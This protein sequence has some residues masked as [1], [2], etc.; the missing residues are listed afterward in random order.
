MDV[1]NIFMIIKESCSSW[2]FGLVVEIV[3]RFS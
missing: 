3:N 1:V 2:I